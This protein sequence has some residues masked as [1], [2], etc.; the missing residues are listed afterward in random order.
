[1]SNFYS[2][3]FGIK[4]QNVEFVVKITDLIENNKKKN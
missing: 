2:G 1:M 4:V 3:K